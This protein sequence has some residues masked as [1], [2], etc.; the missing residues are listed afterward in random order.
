M[1]KRTKLFLWVLLVVLFSGMVPCAADE[2]PVL[3]VLYPG[4]TAGVLSFSTPGS[5]PEGILLKSGDVEVKKEELDA[6]LAK[7]PT[8]TRDEMEK[9]RLYLLEN[10]V[11]P[12]LLL[13][14]ANSQRGTSQGGPLPTQDAVKTYLDSISADVTVSDEEVSAFYEANKDMCGGAKFNQIKDQL[15]DYVLQQKKQDAVKEH[16]R[17]L[18]QRIPITV[19]SDWAKEQASLALDNAVDKARKS[20]LPSLVDFGSTGCRSC[21]MMAPILDTLETKYAGKVNVLF[22]HVQQQAALAA[23]YGITTIPVQVFFDKDGREI[24]RNNGVMSQEQI[25]TKLAE[26]GAAN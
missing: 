5:L 10:M 6:E 12:K 19:A 7:L 13:R 8:G 1:M 17:T 4:V 15:H 20:G 26:T 11:E 14:A 22:I 16:I 21:A 23:R 2:Q 18:G 9:N 3:S 25:E 24:H